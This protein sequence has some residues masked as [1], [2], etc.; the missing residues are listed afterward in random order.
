[1]LVVFYWFLFV[2]VIDMVELFGSYGKDG[3]FVFILVFVGFVFGV[4]FVYGVDKFMLF[5]VNFKFG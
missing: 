5:L 3:K 2:L 1:M 4:V